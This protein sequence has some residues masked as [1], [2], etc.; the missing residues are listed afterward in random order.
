[1]ADPITTTTLVL[2]YFITPLPPTKPPK[3]P[4]EEWEAQVVWTLQSTDHIVTPDER[5][6]FLYAQQLLATVAPVKTMTLRP[7]CLCPYGDGEKECYAPSTDAQ[8]KSGNRGK[9]LV[10]TL[11]AIGPKTKLPKPPTDDGPA[12]R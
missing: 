11:K 7:Y 8:I 2:M 6:C 10:P 1:M 9:P 3:V 4:K 12:D 5:T